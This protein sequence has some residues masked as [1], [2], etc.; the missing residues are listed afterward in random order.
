MSL[1][2]ALAE[3][4]RMIGKKHALNR[5][6]MAQWE[7][8]AKPDALGLILETHMVGERTDFTSLLIVTYVPRQVCLH[9][10]QSTMVC[11][12]QPPPNK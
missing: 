6:E 9:P 8:W 1:H 2:V 11:M 12:P 10:P 7:L 5:G 3:M 4:E